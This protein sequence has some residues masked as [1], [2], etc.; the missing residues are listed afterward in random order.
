MST[1]FDVY[2]VSAHLPTWAE[3]LEAGRDCA[4]PWFAEKGLGEPP[5]LQ[6]QW[7]NEPTVPDLCTPIDQHEKAH[8]V[9]IHAHDGA[10]SFWGGLLDD[11]D[12]AFWEEAFIDEG[13]SSAQV[14]RMRAA[15]LQ[16]RYWTFQ[17]SGVAP[18]AIHVMYG[19]LAAGLAQLTQGYVLSWDVRGPWPV[20]SAEM[21]AR[22]F[23]TTYEQD[24]QEACWEEECVLSL[25][26]E[27]YGWHDSLFF[28]RDL[29]APGRVCL[30][31]EECQRLQ[32]ALRMD[33]TIGQ[34]Q[35]KGMGGILSVT[36][37]AA[38]EEIARYMSIVLH[39]CL[40]HSFAVVV[41]SKPQIREILALLPKHAPQAGTPQE[42]VI[43]LDNDGWGKEHAFLLG[44]R[45]TMHRNAVY[46]HLPQAADPAHAPHASPAAI[47][48]LP[49]WKELQTCRGTWLI[50]LRLDDALQALTWQL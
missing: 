6:L 19:F 7:H 13:F 20:N 15:L 40:G 14:D 37:Y 5:Q 41:K 3:V 39:A 17:R 35:F 47:T 2:P 26:L 45:A 42:L 33:P 36:N 28:V 10:C 8:A 23:R 30:T 1:T 22:H 4:R 21:C 43:G 25:H 34:V 27:A 50:P 31:D 18:A 48:S 16:R 46:A 44:G 38:E 9:S 24:P 29:D 32:L 12:I 49:E 11:D